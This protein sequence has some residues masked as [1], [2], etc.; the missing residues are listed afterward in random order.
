MIVGVSLQ[1]VFPLIVLA[2]FI[3]LPVLAV[4]GT[5]LTTRPGRSLTVASIYE[6]V[7]R[8]LAA[9][10]LISNVYFG[11]PAMERIFV[12]FGTEVPRL[13]SL[14]FVISGVTFFI[15]G[16]IVLAYLLPLLRLLN[17]LS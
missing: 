5:W 9:V 14:A 8:S 11:T 15:L 1:T 17:D 10:L 2:A 6:S 3:L 7:I 12:E 4:L 13:T 16:L